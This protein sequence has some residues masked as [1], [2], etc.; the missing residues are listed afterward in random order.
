MPDSVPKPGHFTTGEPAPGSE[1]L[2]LKTAQPVGLGKARPVEFDASSVRR[3]ARPLPTEP[4]TESDYSGPPTAPLTGAPYT[5]LTG[6]RRAGG[7]RPSGW[8]SNPSRSGAQYTAELPPLKPPRRYSRPIVAG[9]SVLVVVML[10]G[11][12][13][14]GFKLVDSYGLQRPLSQPSIK[15]SEAPLPVPPDPT[16]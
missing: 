9:L 10:T 3:K 11:A 8:H 13:I 6:T 15:K 4:G 12:A 14:G 1:P 7:P 16:V 2:T 5:P